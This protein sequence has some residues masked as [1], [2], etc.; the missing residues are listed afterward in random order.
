MAVWEAVGSGGEPGM[1][2]L[3]SVEQLRGY[4]RRAKVMLKDSKDVRIVRV[5]KD[6]SCK[7]HCADGDSWSSMPRMAARV[8]A[9]RQSYR[10]ACS[11]YTRER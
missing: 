2:L 9:H 3:A 1:Q 4:R 10:K 7:A 8:A 11:T 6:V 5:L